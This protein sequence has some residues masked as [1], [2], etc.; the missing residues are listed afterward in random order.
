MSV[1]F[2]IEKTT[3]K[4]QSGGRNSFILVSN[5]NTYKFVK[6]LFKEEET[7][8]WVGDGGKMQ[9][10]T[11]LDIMLAKRLDCIEDLVLLNGLMYPSFPLFLFWWWLCCRIVIFPE[12]Y[13]SI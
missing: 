13:S 4:G 11:K 5:N 8:N 12:G 10:L 7:R 1:R 6:K 9:N 2:L 3:T